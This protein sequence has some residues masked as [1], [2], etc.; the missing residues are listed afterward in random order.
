MTTKSM[1]QNRWW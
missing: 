1:W